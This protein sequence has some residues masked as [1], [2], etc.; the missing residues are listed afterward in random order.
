MLF[1]IISVTH[2]ETTLAPFII[3]DVSTIPKGPLGE[4]ILKGKDLLSNT[5]KLSVFKWFETD[6]LIS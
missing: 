6:G 1:S 5:R 2:A 4:A 3:P